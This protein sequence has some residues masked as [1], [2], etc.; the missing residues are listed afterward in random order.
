[1]SFSVPIS[2]ANEMF[3]ADFSIFQHVETGKEQVRTLAYSIPSELKG[4]LELVNPT[5]S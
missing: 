5:V 1:M 3:E 4:H 2:K